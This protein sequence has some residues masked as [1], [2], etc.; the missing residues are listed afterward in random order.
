[1]KQIILQDRAREPLPAGCPARLL[2]TWALYGMGVYVLS[3]LVG[4]NP[5]AQA[6]VWVSA[7]LA[8]LAL[9]AGTAEV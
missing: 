3:C 1:M 2:V 8:G 9:A 5:W 7:L 6:S 4:T